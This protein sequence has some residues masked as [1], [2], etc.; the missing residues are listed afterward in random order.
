MSQP[1]LEIIIIACLVSFSCSTLGCYLILRRMAMIGDAI[2]HAV[3]PGIVIAYLISG[4]RDP[5]IMLTGAA[6]LGVL[7]TFLIEIF[8]RKAKLQEDAAIGVTFTSLFAI[9]VILVS[10]FTGQVDLDQ[11]CVLY[12]DI[13]LSPLDRIYTASGIDLGPYSLWT[14]GVVFCLILIFILFSFKEL[15]LTTFDPGYAAVLGINV[16]IWHY[17]LMGFVSITTVAAFKSVGAILVVAF[18]VAPA[19]TAYLLTDNFAKMLIYSC[20]SGLISSIGGYYL[21]AWLNASIAGGIAT[22]CGI[23]FA[24]VFFFSPNQGYLFKK[25]QKNPLEQ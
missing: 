21:A 25:L 13:A 15:F 16:A 3:L 12:G 6:I 17:L 4:D 11:E 23:V 10:A 20:I 14:M 9:G 7:T 2:S 22:V 1:D 5:I 8:H 19:A 24:L 18:L